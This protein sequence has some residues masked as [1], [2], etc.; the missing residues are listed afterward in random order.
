ME[1]SQIEPP[2]EQTTLKK[3][4]LIRVNHICNIMS[5][6]YNILPART[7]LVVS[8]GA[9]SSPLSDQAQGI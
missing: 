7:S 4:R 8:L 5:N 1:G 9:G 6:R 2:P 3:A